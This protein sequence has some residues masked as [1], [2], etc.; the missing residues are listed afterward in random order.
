MS[1]RLDDVFKLLG[2][3]TRLRILDLLYQ[4]PACVCQITGVL[5]EPQAKISRHLAKLRDADLVETLRKDQFVEYSLNE[6]NA[7]L[8]QVMALVQDQH[9]DEALEEERSR[10]NLKEYY[11]NQC[12]A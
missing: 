7:F 6:K 11:L 2:D 9:G 8:M 1:N 12:K 4:G 5:E 3:E 10:Q